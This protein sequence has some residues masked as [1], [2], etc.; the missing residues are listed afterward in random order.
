LTKLLADENIPKKTVEAL[1]QREIDIT[2][3]VD[4]SPGLSD[5]AVIELANN[6][7]RV[8]VTFDKDF[9]ELIFR[10]R[11][12]VRGLILLRLAPTSPEHIAERIGHIMAQKIPI[13]NKII[14]VREDSVRVTPLR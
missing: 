9:G 10:E 4:S 2:S 11:L 8:I 6:E 1:K 13:E 3:V 12:E 7:K 14:V 5:R